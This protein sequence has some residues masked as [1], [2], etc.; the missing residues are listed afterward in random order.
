[1]SSIPLSQSSLGLASGLSRLGQLTDATSSRIASGRRL[2]HPSADPAG[3][4]QSAKLDGEHTRLRAV[5][6]NLQNGVSRLQSTT[7]QLDVLGRVTTRLSELAA[8]VTDPTRGPAASATYVTEF[9]Q[10]QTQLRQ[11][12]GGSAAEIG[13]TGV[14]SAQGSFN[15]QELFGPGP[16]DTLVIGEAPPATYTPPVLNLRTGA[17]GELIRQDASGAFTLQLDASTA[18]AIN[19]RLQAA[20][21][22]IADSQAQVGAGLSRLDFASSVATTAATNHEAALSTIRDADLAT[23]LTALSRLKMLTES[24]TAMLAQ[25]R[26]TSAKLLPLLSRRG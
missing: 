7:G 1:M 4:G 26:D 12:I 8:L 25:A 11:I 18:P 17:L 6:V 21:A 16:N 9:T 19:Q 5:E 22:Q 3:L 13:G 2:D 24:H 20:T 23:E 14:A 15:H 10:L